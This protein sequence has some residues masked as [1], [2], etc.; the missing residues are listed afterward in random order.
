MPLT[1]GEAVGWA[2]EARNDSPIYNSSP[3]CS[4]PRSHAAW[5]RELLLT[6]FPNQDLPEALWGDNFLRLTEAAS[7][8]TISF[9]ALEALRAWALL[10]H[11]PPA[12]LSGATP[13]PWDYTFTTDY[14]G[15]TTASC[16]PRPHFARASFYTTT[17]DDLAE[18]SAKLRAPLCKCIGGRQVLAPLSE[19]LSGASPPPSPDQVLFSPSCPTPPWTPTT[20]PFSIE[21]VLAA[22]SPPTFNASVPLWLQNLDPHSL[23][24]LNVHV[25][26]GPGYWV[27]YLRC[28][29][30]VNGVMARVLDTRYIYNPAPGGPRRV[31]RQRTWREGAWALYAGAEGEKYVNFGD[32]VN[33][34][35]V[36]AKRLHVKREVVEEMVLP[37]ARIGIAAPAPPMQPVWK[38]SLGCLA[39]ACSGGVTVAC[40]DL[41]GDVVA[42]DAVSGEERWRRKLG[43]GAHGT[44]VSIRGGRVAVGDSS[45]M[46]H[47][48][49][50]ETGVGTTVLEVK[51]SG[52]KGFKQEVEHVAWGAGGDVLA[53]AA[54][55]AVL[56]VVL[57][58]LSEERR[59]FANT[60]YSVCFDTTGEEL[61]V[62]RYGGV[63]W[64]DQEKAPLKIG[65][66]AVLSIAISPNDAHIAVGC[67]DKRVRIFSRVGAGN[68]VAARDW[69]GFDGPVSQVKWSRSGK[70]LAMLGGGGDGGLLVVPGQFSK[71]QG[72]VLCSAPPQDS[73]SAGRKFEEITWVQDVQREELLVAVGGG[74]SRAYVFDVD[75]HDEAVPRRCSPVTSTQLEGAR[76][77]LWS[78]RGDALVVCGGGN[79]ESY[80]I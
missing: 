73:D 64:W 63:D 25:A 51:G 68:L 12:H 21:S 37:T 32:E 30:R 9:S 40:A 52:S 31:L 58:G 43:E 42:V 78:D 26:S 19:K 50:A 39:V 71:G 41:E 13:D 8:L 75:K 17:A 16:S 47:I 54:G 59:V 49:E 10:D 6:R 45:G 1:T 70:Y 33:Q 79:L 38:R 56:K 61:A 57:S 11:P 66:A 62:G 27:A 55:K 24:C 2:I 53:A 36:A 7:G 69:V 4:T 65:A 5:K 76:G 34:A 15:S 14:P 29:V 22:N 60:V 23:S 35:R 77:A 46:V 18:G 80:R 3:F 72:G 74:G 48:W 67:L 44:A 28:F 20:A